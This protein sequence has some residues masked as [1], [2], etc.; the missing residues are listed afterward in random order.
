MGRLESLQLE[1]VLVVV[2]R[3]FGGILLGTGGLV[4]AYREATADALNHAEIVDREVTVRRTVR[5]PY[6][7]MNDV[8]R[9]LKDCNA[10]ILRQDWEDG[11]CL[12]DYEIN[13]AYGTI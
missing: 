10:K 8:M 9:R 11:A 4:V 13:K 5:F 12:I 6:E 7:Q 3:Y 2:V 1:N